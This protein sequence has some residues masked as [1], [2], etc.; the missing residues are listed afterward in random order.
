M[1][2]GIVSLFPRQ[3]KD[4]ME[5]GGEGAE[6]RGHCPSVMGGGLLRCG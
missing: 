4:F 2:L 1:W 5:F 3:L 6:S